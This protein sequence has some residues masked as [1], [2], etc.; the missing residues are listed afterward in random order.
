MVQS[1]SEHFGPATTRI[2]IDAFEVAWRRVQTSKLSLLALGADARSMLLNHL[3]DIANTGERDRQH[4][5]DGALVR[6]CLSLLSVPPLATY[7]FYEVL[8]QRQGAYAR[9]AARWDRKRF[10]NTIPER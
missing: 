10:K 9:A 2:L 3:V 8:M 5:I 6:F 4:L 7:S 1:P